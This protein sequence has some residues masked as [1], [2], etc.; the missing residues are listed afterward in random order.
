MNAILE[1]KVKEL[2]EFAN[3]HGLAEVSWQDGSMKVAFRRDPYSVAPPAAAAAPAAE[4]KGPELLYVRSPI[5]GSFRRSISKDR[6][7]LIMVGNHIKP[8]DKLG[9]VDCMKIPTDVVSFCGGEVREIVVEDGQ[10]V[11]YGQPLFA[12]LPDPGESVSR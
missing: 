8:G 7:P 3:R 2:L 4:P 9:I 5:V 10:P 12:V 1:N 11:E 6:P